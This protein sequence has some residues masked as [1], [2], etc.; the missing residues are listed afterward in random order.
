M[1]KMAL[2]KNKKKKTFKRGRERIVFSTN[3]VG[4][5]HYPHRKQERGK[6]YIVWKYLHICSGRH[7]QESSQQHYL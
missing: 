7:A 1:S 2:P 6:V 3:G 4:I 5:I